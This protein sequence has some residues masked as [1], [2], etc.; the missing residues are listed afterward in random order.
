MIK[1]ARRNSLL[2]LG[3]AELV[4]GDFDVEQ[5]DAGSSPPRG[6]L[7]L[8]EREPGLDVET[9][10]RWQLSILGRIGRRW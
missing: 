1:K 8:A 2:L 4:V 9:I 7:H 10:E 3:D 6:E 5:M